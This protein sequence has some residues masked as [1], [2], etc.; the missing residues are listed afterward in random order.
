MEFTKTFTYLFQPSLTLFHTDIIK[1]AFLNTDTGIKVL[2]V[3][4]GDKGLNKYSEKDGVFHILCDLSHHTAKVQLEHI[5]KSTFFIGSY[6][7][8]RYPKVGVILF[9]ST[10]GKAYN[11]FLLSDYRNMYSIDL[12]ES[13]K[14]DFKI[15][16]GEYTQAFNVLSYDKELQKKLADRIKVKNPS[17]LKQLASKLVITEEIVDILEYYT[18]GT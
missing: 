2:N 9:K 1:E 3:F 15:A 8:N 5:S 16:D 14:E 7:I 6:I 4:L 10:K 12:L 17:E 13:M 18:D 11:N